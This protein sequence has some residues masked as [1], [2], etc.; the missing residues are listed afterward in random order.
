MINRILLFLLLLLVSGCAM[1]RGQYDVPDI[2]LPGQYRNAARN[3]PAP[4][5]DNSAVDPET[6]R[7]IRLDEWWRAFNSAQLIEIVD[8]GLANN[9]DIRMATLRLAQAK[10]R[11]DQARAGFFPSVTLPIGAAIQ[12]PG[13]EI[14]TVPAGS[15]NTS[16]QKSYQASVRGTYRVDVWGEQSALADVAAYQLRQAAFDRDNVQRNVVANIVSAFIDYLSLNDRIQ[17]ARETE[18]VLD[19]TLKSIHRRLEAGD[20]TVVD[21]DQQKASVFATRATILD[22]ERQRENVRTMLAFLMG[23]VPEALKL[24]DDGLDTMNLPGVIPALPSELLLRRPD[25]RVA[26]ARLLAADAD[27]DVA[28]ARLLPPVD[29]ST[30]IGRSN[31]SLSQLFAPSSLFWNALV[32]ITATVFD[33]GKQASQTENARRVHEEVVENYARTVYLAVREVESALAAIRMNEH[34][35]Q[36]QEEATTA[37]HRAWKG[38][39][40]VYAAG[41]LDYLS[42]LDAER[43]Y[44][45]YLD[46]YQRIRMDRFRGYVDLF[47]ALGGGVEF[48]GSLPESAKRP[49][50]AAT[51]SP[52]PVTREVPAAKVFDWVAAP[53][54]E[55]DEY[56][57]VELPGLHHRSLIGPAWRDLRAR[58]PDLMKNR[59]IRPRLE[60]NVDRGTEE[61]IAWYRLFVGRFAEPGSAHAFCAAL[62][63]DFQRCRVVSSH[64]EETVP[65]PVSNAATTLGAAKVGVDNGKAEGEAVSAVSLAAPAPQRIKPTVEIPAVPQPVSAPEMPAQEPP[66]EPAPEIGEV[67]EKEEYRPAYTLQTGAFSTLDKAAESQASWRARSYD[68]HISKISDAHGKPLYAVHIGVYMQRSKAA[69][70]LVWLRREAGAPVIVKPILVNR[71]GKPESLSAI[72]TNRLDVAMDQNLSDNR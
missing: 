38:S 55:A 27:I 17:I 71:H 52:E 53:G 22:L 31:L 16:V 70:A 57:Q 46:D 18:V 6:P 25:V 59:S 30:Q 72:S 68:P 19:A 37:A 13:G 48:S 58:Y 9:L 69:A 60:G 21:Y 28:R 67:R 49:G 10:T 43:S 34:R 4:T 26:E 12:A 36:A 45:R 11:S 39:A 20:A 1:K 63:A 5:N 66:A 62:R 32:T 50:L 33:A 54:S 23:T 61:R 8:R 42:L 44:H 35:L 56:W 14:G 40:E 24:P 65:P 41:G 15:R 7:N 51:P 29:L 3:L 47:Q 2:P 64:S